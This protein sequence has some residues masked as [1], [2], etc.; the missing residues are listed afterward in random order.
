MN[1]QALNED[2]RA[3]G[4]GALDLRASASMSGSVFF[5][6]P[7]MKASNP[8]RSSLNS[9]NSMTQT[10]ELD[11]S[12]LRSK[13]MQTLQSGSGGTGRSGQGKT[14]TEGDGTFS[15]FAV[16]QPKL[17]NID[18]SPGGKELPPH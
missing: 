6:D 4:N 8:L 15:H 17:F 7:K 16:Q 9:P 18:F 3:D 12:L 13:N 11:P 2:C 10:I 5:E 1:K 14:L